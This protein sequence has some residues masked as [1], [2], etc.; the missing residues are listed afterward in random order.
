MQ[1]LMIFNNFL[2]LHVGDYL[3][4]ETSCV[5]KFVLT[6]VVIIKENIFFE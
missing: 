4:W 5:I 3:V 1:F 2:K 6:S